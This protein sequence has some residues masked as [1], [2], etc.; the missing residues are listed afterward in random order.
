MMS[1]LPKD[2]VLGAATAAYQVE[3]SSTVDGKG[4]ILWDGFLENK[5]VFS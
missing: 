5:D 2:F 3:G 4:R 1:K